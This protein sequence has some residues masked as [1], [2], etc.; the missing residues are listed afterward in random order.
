MAYKKTEWIDNVTPINAEKLNKIE[1][2][3]YETEKSIPTKISQL[4]NDSEYID[5][6]K[7]KN[8]LTETVEGNVLDATM[9]K[10]LKDDIDNRAL[11]TEVG[12]LSGLT[13][14]TKTSLVDAINEST[15]K[16]N[17]LSID[18]GYKDSSVHGSGDMNTFTNNGKYY[19]K[20][21]TN[22]PT[23]S[24]SVFDVTNNGGDWDVAQ[25]VHATDQ[26]ISHIRY[27]NGISWKVKQIAT[28]DKT[29]ILFQGAATTTFTLAK[30]FSGYDEFKVMG[31]TASHTHSTY[32]HNNFDFN[33]L[34]NT[35]S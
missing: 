28:T 17:V 26:G 31:Y 35:E 4:I 32:T 25:I 23:G 9:G 5:A 2:G 11:K 3:I 19:G 21:L 18:R 29:D 1:N 20:N 14:I 34:G 16:I 8:N 12:T 24:W 13:T 15:N 7:V 30:S 27:K 22:M 10:V 6:S 33:T